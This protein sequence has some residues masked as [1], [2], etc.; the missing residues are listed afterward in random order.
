[1]RFHVSISAALVSAACLAGS[2]TAYAHG[3]VIS[4]SLTFNALTANALTF[5]FNALTFNALTFNALTFNA[6]TVKA[7][8]VNL[9]DS[10][11]SDLDELNGVTAEVVDRTE[12]SHHA[13]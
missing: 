13:H 5:T 12:G 6:L 9:V 4:N 10:A 3:V 2:G 11:G 1:M 8:T 7:L